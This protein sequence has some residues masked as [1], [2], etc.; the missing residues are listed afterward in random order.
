MIQGKKELFSKNMKSSLEGWLHILN[1]SF[2]TVFV[3]LQVM[4]DLISRS[5][6]NSHSHTDIKNVNP[7]IKFTLFLVVVND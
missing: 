6:T 2:M 3:I 5:L 7:L 1:Y 4:D